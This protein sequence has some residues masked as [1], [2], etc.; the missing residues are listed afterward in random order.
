MQN[1]ERI[2]GLDDPPGLHDDHTM[3]HGPHHR[4]IMRDQKV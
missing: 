2:T 3:R 1:F 4:E